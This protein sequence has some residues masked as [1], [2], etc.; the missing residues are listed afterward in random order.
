[1]IFLLHDVFEATLRRCPDRRAVFEE[2]GR[3][4]TYSE[5]DLLAQHYEHR[6]AEV[7]ADAGP[8]YVGILAHVGAHSIAAI[9]AVLR[10][11]RAYV[12]LDDAAPPE[13]LAKIIENTG[14]QVV[15]ADAAFRETHARTLEHA[16]ETIWLSADEAMGR[17]ARLSGDI[18]RRSVLTDDLAYVLHSSGSTGVPKGIMLTHR[19]ARTFVDWMDS[20]FKP[21]EDDV[22]MSRAP[23]KFDLSVWDIFNALKAGSTVVCFDWHRRRQGARRHAEYVELMRR[24]GASILYTTPSVLTALLNHGGLADRPVALRTVMYAGEPFAPAQLKRLMDAL[25]AVRFANIYGPTE[26]NIITCHWVDEVGDSP[27]PLGREVADTQILIV[28]P[29]TR[30]VCGPGELGEIWCRGGTVTLG[31]LGMPDATEAAVAQSP[32]HPYP[33]RFW[34]TG[35]YGF[36]D[37]RDVLH[38]RGRRDHMVK[39]NGYRIELG[40][41][42]HALASVPGLDTGVVT[43][44]E[45]GGER[46]LVCHYASLP[47]HAVTPEVAHAHLAHRLPVYMLPRAYRTHEA[48]PY[49]SSGKVDRLALA[50]LD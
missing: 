37:A 38:Y 33:A 32:V 50:K 22:I 31:Y 46:V 48:L 19:N 1:M 3:A 29:Q 39:I 21:G 40:D 9:L 7:L 11:G 16:R 24:A 26:T 12:P 8:P 5:L 30:Q 45:N 44:A 6:L 47:G 20:E 49:T 13:R 35:D 36:R 2:S 28:D 14:L 25:P 41:V 17:Q 18:P 42:E 10:S 34:R 4:T 43:V 27:V 23:L 15:F